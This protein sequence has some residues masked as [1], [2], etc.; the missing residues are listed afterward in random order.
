M[1]RLDRGLGLQH[2]DAIRVVRDVV[3]ELGGQD[4]A[5]VRDDLRP[6][7]VLG[8]GDVARRGLGVGGL[9]DQH[10][11]AHG[12]R[13]L[14]LCELLRTVVVGGERDDREPE[15]G[16]VLLEE[17]AVLLVALLL[18]RRE[19][20][21]DVGRLLRVGLGAR[22]QADHDERQHRQG[23]QR[24]HQLAALLALAPLHHHVAEDSEQQDP[25]GEDQ[26]PVA[27]DTE[28]R[29]AVRERGEHQRA[30]HRAG[31]RAAATGDRGAADHD[32]GHR[33]ELEQV[34]LVAGGDAVDARRGEH[35]RDRGEHAH[36]RVDDQGDALDVDARQPRSLG[37]ATDGIDLAAEP[38]A[39]QREHAADRDGTGDQHGH[40][41]AARAEHAEQRTREEHLAAHPDRDR[42]RGQRRQPR[43]LATAR[44]AEHREETD[45]E[46]ADH[47]HPGDRD[48]QRAV[49][50]CE[51]VA[52]LQARRIRRDQRAAAIR[53][54]AGERDDE[55]RDAEPADPDA[56]PRADRRAGEEGEEDRAG[57][58]HAEGVLCERGDHTG[59]SDAG[60]D[61]QID[62]ADQ[63]HER[64]ADGDDEQHR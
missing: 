30:E 36:Q 29:H 64:H 17:L 20:E 57:R 45:R 24:E 51:I 16:G 12:Q 39:P 40:R 32:G 3:V 63:D 21:R 15:V 9:D 56:V 35:A 46:H 11:R 42:R 52:H 48:R 47:E 28:Q 26:L 22:G 60:T 38:G 49:Q 25:A 33:V 8:E 54:E 5:V 27:I 19:Q 55:R 31:D 23:K 41:D 44:L 18:Q 62:T 61:G 10:L 58:R 50:A 34:P 53:L 7:A 59:Q 4:R 1:R 6:A 2:A 14:D 37:V 13:V 43:G